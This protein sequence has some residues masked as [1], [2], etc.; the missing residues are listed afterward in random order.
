MDIFELSRSQGAGTQTHAR[1]NEWP[2]CFVLFLFV[3]RIIF[4]NGKDDIF[5]LFSN[6]L[7]CSVFVRDRSVSVCNNVI[8]VDL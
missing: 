2:N 3:R 4:F 1:V 7:I 5:L 6:K 8:L